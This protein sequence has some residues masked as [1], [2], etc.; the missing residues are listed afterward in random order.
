MRGGCY[1][2]ARVSCEIVDLR[3]A[4]GFNRYAENAESSN[5]AHVWWQGEGDI[6]TEGV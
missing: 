3:G 6:K 1:P 2:E 5:F 4:V